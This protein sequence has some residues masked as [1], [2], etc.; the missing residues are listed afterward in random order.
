M[1]KI[2]LLSILFFP[3]F[4]YADDRPKSFNISGVKMF[5]SVYTDTKGTATGKDDGFKVSQSTRLRLEGKTE[6]GLNAYMNY[7]DTNQI[8]PLEMLVNYQRDI[9]SASLG[10]MDIVLNETEFAGYNRRM[11]GVK[12]GLKTDKFHTQVFAATNRGI[13]KTAAYQGNIGH[14]SQ[15]IFED[16]YV[17]RKYYQLLPEEVVNAVLIDDGIPENGG[18]FTTLTLNTDYTIG[19]QLLTIGTQL[20]NGTT[21]RV[22]VLTTS[23]ETDAI[24]QVAYEQSGT[25]TIKGPDT[26]DEEICSYYKLSYPNL[27]EGKEVIASG[28]STLIRGIDYSVNYSDGSVYFAA[29]T[30]FTIDYDYAAKT[31][32]LEPPVLPGSER[33]MVN[34]SQKQ[35]ELDYTI[36]YETGEV[37]FFDSHMS[38]IFA[39]SEIKIEYET[40]AEGNR[41]SLAGMRSGYAVKKG[42][43]VGCTYLFKSDAAPKAKTTQAMT[44]MRQQ[45]FGFDTNIYLGER[46][47]ITG[48]VAVSR[49][50]PGNNGRICIDDMEG[51]DILTRWKVL[52]SGVKSSAEK[53]PEHV[54]HPEDVD[55]HQVL[56]IMAGMGTNTI[57]QILAAPLDLSLYSIIDCWIKT[58]ASTTVTLCLYSASTS[59]F[60]YD[61]GSDKTGEYLSI[62]RNLSGDAVIYGEPDLKTI[63]RIQFI[64]NN[65][66][67]ETATLYIDDLISKEGSPMN[68]LA[69][70][71]ETEFSS[72][73]LKLKVGVKDIDQGFN[74]IGLTDFESINDSRTYQAEAQL[75][76][77]QST[78]LL[79]KYENKLK[80]MSLLEKQLKQD[81]LS[82]GIRFEPSDAFK[83]NIDYKQEDENDKK[84]VHVIDNVNKKTTISFDTNKENI[85]HL[86]RFRCFNRL[87]NINAKDNVHNLHTSSN[88]AYLRFNLEP[89]Q[90]I[91]LIPEYKIRLTKDINKDTNMSKEENILGAINIASSDKLSTILRYAHDNLSNIVLDSEQYNQTLSMELG[92]NVEKRPSLN[93]FLESTRKKRLEHQ[94]ITSQTDTSGGDMKL[95]S[96]PSEKWKW[97]LQYRFSRSNSDG[98]RDRV[99]NYTGELT[100]WFK[101]WK[102]AGTSSLT[103]RICQ[104]IINSITTDTYLL[105]W[106]T[107]FKQGISTKLAYECSEKDTL[108]M[109][110]PSIKIGY[111]TEKWNTSSEFKQTRSNNKVSN[112]KTTDYLLSMGAE[113]KLKDKIT[114]SQSLICTDNKSTHKTCYSSSTEVKWWITKML[115]L[116]L[117]HVWSD[118]HNKL[119]AKQ[120]YSSNKVDMDMSIVF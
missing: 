19:T 106:E 77:V 71:I 119:D 29:K 75:P 6:E 61:L 51:D 79:L 25:L 16:E 58:Q 68:G 76:L 24:I 43:D 114:V 84:N 46:L 111:T 45:I 105:I 41:Y 93:T 47:T 37:R 7:D 72:D 94:S 3:A 10:H 103:P 99:D 92:I 109:D 53:T 104:D 112:L 21:T 66:G 86:A 30:D 60:S 115:N 59:Y 23:A 70:K 11:F 38:G 96:S 55:N 91:E 34:G 113:Y 9:F 90:G 64:F 8:D 63:N 89:V 28:S 48:E 40:V 4:L 18:G 42:L 118:I 33:V 69:K 50:E 117:R 54:S 31:Y 67:S 2:L 15:S 5:S 80:S 62:K 108:S 56:R 97:L 32:W 88:H 57:E 20:L 110:I 74:P 1:K 12:S 102:Q 95:A 100:R 22:L 107:I 82:A 78:M 17:Q 39:D 52:S 81:I 98:I 14:N 120:D 85:L 26:A 36:N 87:M 35:R 27:I 65:T 116:A 13:P 49:K 83:V 44:Q 73:H 101:V